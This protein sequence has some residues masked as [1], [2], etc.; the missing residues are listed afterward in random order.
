MVVYHS[1]AEHVFRWQGPLCVEEA[2]AASGD[3]FPNIWSKDDRS[4]VRFRRESV[5]GS[6]QHPRS[7]ERDDGACEEDTVK[8]CEA[9]VSF[10]CVGSFDVSG[11]SHG[12]LQG[13][14]H[15][16]PLDGRVQEIPVS[17]VAQQRCSKQMW[18]QSGHEVISASLCCW[19][20]GQDEQKGRLEDNVS[21][22][23]GLE[24]SASLSRT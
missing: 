19:P 12:G 4:D 13:G 6:R 7:T 23:T 22:V 3:L 24:D 18:G 5:L 10:R 17:M 11:A 8:E 9:L 14:V 21:A 1:T 15:L 20:L 16:T 2:F